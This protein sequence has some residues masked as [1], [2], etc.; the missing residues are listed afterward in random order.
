M[1]LKRILSMAVCTMALML[2][3]Y[4]GPA[5]A[6]ER[7]LRV[8]LTV[9]GVD[10]FE[11]PRLENVSGEPTGYTVGAM[12]G[13]A[14]YGD[15]KISDSQ[16]SIKLV[17]DA[18]QISNTET[19]AVLYTSERGTDY[20]AI[21]PNSSLTWFKGYKWHGCFVYKR[22]AGGKLTVINYVNL[23]DYV[24]GVLPYEIDPDW[25]AEALKAQAVCARAYAV[26]TQ[27]HDSDGYDLC[28]TTHCQVYYGGANATPES[29]AA[30]DVTAGE[31]ITF[32]GKAVEGNFFSSD[33][34]ATEDALN[35]WGEDVDYLIGKED[36]YEEN[37]EEW[38]ISLSAEEVQQRLSDMGYTIGKI[39]NV[40]VTKRTG[41]DNVNEVTVT[42][43]DGN[44]V[45]LQRSL[46]RTVF[47]L[48]SIRYKITPAIG[49]LSLPNAHTINISPSVHTVAVD[50]EIVTPR[51]Y[52]INGSNYYKL[53]DIAC[54]MNGTNSQFNVIWNQ[55][56][57]CIEIV[58]N[59]PYQPVGGEMDDSP[60]SLSSCNPSSFSVKL[61]GMLVS[62]AGY[63]IGGNTYYRIRDIGSAIGF[64]VGFLNPYVTIRSAISPNM[65]NKPTATSFTFKGLG[66][67][68]S[69]GMSQWGAYAMAKQGYTYEEI[70]KFYYTGIEISR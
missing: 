65:V 41:L 53:R 39:A 37:A 38:T 6:S 8:A 69:V 58:S 54:I 12:S 16:L 9:Q 52:N 15:S 46:V 32:N 43:T 47:G 50:N 44:T 3:I 20:L 42:D 64:D 2:G 1:Q 49:S 34:G 48:K 28:N 26:C 36:P 18:F 40:E 56:E 68:H 7:V 23:E 70:L 29:D 66:W 45:V 63:N 17:D 22:V 51:G 62:L 61:N 25:P 55:D 4:A 35:V 14:F 59:M 10:S 33:G 24:K 5:F 60:L 19:G 31:V 67:G 57:S 27:K 11:E 13:T 21:K 30:V